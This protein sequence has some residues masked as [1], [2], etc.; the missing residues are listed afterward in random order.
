MHK[1]EAIL[2]ARSVD[3]AWALYAGSMARMGFPFL[4]YGGH[5]LIG[6]TGTTSLDEGI[7]LSNLPDGLDTQI[8][9]RQ[10]HDSI[11]M[12]GWMVRN[13]GWRSWDWAN[14]R[15]RDGRLSI[16]EAGCLDLF[17]SHGLRAGI[18]ISLSDRVPRV[19]A[20]ILLIGPAGIAQTELDHRWSECQRYGVLLTSVLHQRLANLPYRQPDQILTLRQREVLELTGSGMTTQEIAL[21]LDLT[22]GTVEKHMR[23]ARKALGARTSAQAVLLAMS[24]RQI[25]VDPGEACT[26]PPPRPAPAAPADDTPAQ[27]WSYIEAMERAARSNQI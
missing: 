25:F 11:P 21:G 20:G 1:I 9:E 2:A 22:P 19:R 23:L 14:Q 3:D 4:M 5:R 13:H 15:R 16:A 26:P 6:G 7:R 24:R 8:L 12:L 10:F 18:A 27:P 17:A